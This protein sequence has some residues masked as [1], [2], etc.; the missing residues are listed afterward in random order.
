MARGEPAR[1]LDC[2]RPIRL[3][4]PAAARESR[5]VARRRAGASG[6]PDAT[7]RRKPRD[8]RSRHDRPG[9]SLRQAGC[10]W[11]LGPGPGAGGAAALALTRFQRRGRRR[12]RRFGPQLSGR[13]A[14][15]P[16]CH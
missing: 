13:H 7:V 1:C 8:A 6:V 5:Y 12:L 14:G 15:G 2:R 3:G 11:R 10:R 4:D 16:Q 9:G